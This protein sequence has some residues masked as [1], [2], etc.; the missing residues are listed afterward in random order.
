MNI[1]RR[2]RKYAIGLL[3]QDP[4]DVRDYQLAEIQAPL[5]DAEM[6]IEY[7]LRNEMTPVGRQNW[8]TC[9]AWSACAVKEFWDSKEAQSI[10]DL[11]EKF[12]Y[13]NTKKIS[14]L[15]GMQG[16]ML[17]NALKS[18]CTYGAPETKDYPD[19][20]ETS[21]EKYVKAE[22]SN[23]IYE[24][25]KKYKGLTYWTVHKGL[26]E[27]KSAIYTNK[28]PVAIGMKWYPSFYKTGKDGRLPLPS[29]DAYGGHAVSCIGWTRDKLWFKN[30]WGT[31]F[32]DN[33]YFYVPVADFSK[34]D[35]WNAK[36]LLDIN[37]EGLEGWVA[38][39]YL[40][41][42]AYK[43]GTAVS[44]TTSLRLRSEATTNSDIVKTLPKGTKCRIL[45]DEVVAANGYNWQKIKLL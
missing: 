13:H 23:D 45:N 26:S 3:A 18:I 28:C 2:R 32:G 31:S 4:I 29:G 24:K 8:G 9:T 25:A 21:W 1:F 37:T 43:T 44:P 12:V 36:V 22:P 17:S 42:K 7:N 41:T 14:G 5:G 20:K 11:S 15:W 16:D 33:G 38:N 35:I 39:K 19:I 40:E 6:P 30:S 34:Y 10:I 27:I